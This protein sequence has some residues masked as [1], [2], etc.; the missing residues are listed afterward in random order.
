VEDRA[1]GPLREVIAGETLSF[2]RMGALAQLLAVKLMRSP[3]CRSRQTRSG[4][5][6]PASSLRCRMNFAP[7]SRFIDHDYDREA[8]LRSPRRSRAQEGFHRVRS[9]T[10]VS[11]VEVFGE[12]QAA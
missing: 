8:A 4:C 5:T 10:W 7:L 2:E 6:R 1:A 3:N 9:R 11:D 12:E